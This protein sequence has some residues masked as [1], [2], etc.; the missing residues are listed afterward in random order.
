MVE[1]HPTRDIDRVFVGRQHEMAQLKAALDDALSGQGRLVMLVGEPGIG[2]T[3]TAQELALIAETRGAQVLWGCCYEEEGAPPYWPW[4]QAIRSYVQQREPDQLRTEMGAGAADIAEIV[5][6]VRDRIPHLEPHTALEPEQARFRLFDSISTF[7]KNADQPQGVMLV[8]D[9]LHWADEPSLLLLQFLAR[10][11]RDSR[12]LV[13]GCYRDAELSPRHPLSETVAN[14]SR[15][16][17][18]QRERLRGLSHDDTWLFIESTAGIRPRQGLVDTV[19][20]HT[21]GNPFFITEVIRL[22]SERGE[23]SPEA[24]GDVTIRIPEGVRAVMGQRV[25]RLS[26]RC[27][28]TL[29]TASVIGR[30]FDFNQLTACCEGVTEEELLRSIDEA[31][32]ARL[33]QESPDGIERYQFSHALVQQAFSE[34]QSVS[35]RVR[36][37]AR[38]AV[39]LEGLYG[40]EP[41][42]H[43]PELAHHFA[44]AEPI[45]GTEKL[46]YYSLLAGEQALA[47]YAH[48]EALGHFK[49]ALATKEGQLMDAE[50][51]ALMFGLGRAMGATG[52]LHEAWTTLG[53]AFEYYDEARDLRNAIAVAE[54]PLLFASGVPQATHMVERA[55]MLVPSGSH[56]AGRLLSR[57]GLLLNLETGNYEH[58]QEAFNGALLIAQREKDVAL[59]MRTLANAADADWY[60]IRGEDALKKSLRVIELARRANDPRTEVWPRFLAAFELIAKGDPGSARE[61][62]HE[63]LALADRL[64]DRG[65]IPLARMTNEFVCRHMGD[66][67]N[68]RGY[69]DR[70]LDLEPRL[71]WILGF[72]AVLEYELGD[73]DKGEAYVERLLEVMRLTAPGPVSEYASVAVLI[74]LVARI[75]GNL[76]LLDIAERAAETIISAPSATPLYGMWATAGLALIAVLR[77][78]ARKARDL[79]KTLKSQQGT[80]LTGVLAVDRLLGL[81]CRTSGQ[82]DKSITHFDDAMT[83][84]RKAGYQ[85][86][87]AMTL[88]EYADMLLE[89][90]SEGDRHK[91]MK[92]L[93]ESLTISV[94]LGMRT[95]TEWVAALQDQVES[96]PQMGSGFPG[97][98]TRRES[99]VLRCIALGKSNRE[100][101]AELVLSVRTVERHIT[102]IYGKINARGRADATAY[103][104]G[105]NLTDN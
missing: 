19:Y 39:A 23:L 81:L 85:P 51:A 41:E 9:D 11:L 48:E 17:A 79:Y 38:I 58:A 34:D 15:E 46:V 6:E 47:T 84:C 44:E 33:I 83:F 72:R 54:Y 20:A 94:E 63:M 82:V 90:N 3:R 91:A 16:P 96:H 2:K 10:Q 27:K 95:L 102:N 40:S 69:I 65:L 53:R 103:A 64:D 42:K 12:L 31:L 92:L 28:L 88:Y 73:F 68:V 35:R 70:G 104:L 89:R 24:T 4:V 25:N 50:T 57:Y 60:Q 61:H 37:H 67:E 66:W 71:P 13:V 75:T 32:A 21:E 98:L 55:L 1:S 77:T 87:L 62:A 76:Y 59:E 56:D 99:E 45:V 74:P 30:D 49:R 7:L 86:E 22:L 97:G 105:H 80:M 26:K 18:L 8:L 29:T 101:A 5:P 14:L 36:L 93:N 52:Q 78:Q 43:A 100:I